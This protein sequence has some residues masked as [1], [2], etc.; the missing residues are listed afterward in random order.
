MANDV[1]AGK[2]VWGDEAVVEVV[3]WPTWVAGTGLRYPSSAFQL[4]CQTPLATMPVH[5]RGLR[6]G[7]LRVGGQPGRLIVV[8]SW[9]SVTSVE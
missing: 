6:R 9:T 8:P 5:G 2:G 7:A 4:V 3:A 1:G